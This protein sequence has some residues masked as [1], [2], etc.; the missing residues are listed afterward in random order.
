M[1]PIMG[2]NGNH[3]PVRKSGDGQ[4]FRSHYPVVIILRL[5]RKYGLFY[6]EA[7]PWLKSNVSLFIESC[8]NEEDT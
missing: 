7:N 3:A 1:P 8:S 6:K 4:V 5:C 2:I